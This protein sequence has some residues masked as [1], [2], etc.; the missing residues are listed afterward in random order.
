MPRGIKP[1]TTA[2][3]PARDH[4]QRPG[5]ACFPE[6]NRDRHTVRCC[7][8]RPVPHTEERGL[9]RVVGGCAA[10]VCVCVCEVGGLIIVGSPVSGWGRLEGGRHHRE[11]DSGRARK[12]LRQRRKHAGVHHASRERRH[13]KLAPARP[14]RGGVGGARAARARR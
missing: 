3:Y 9:G 6:R 4:Q 7:P 5:S 14:G 8:R 1:K 10:V 2:R 11:Q 13:A 12:R